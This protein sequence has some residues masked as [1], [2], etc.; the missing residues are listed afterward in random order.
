MKMDE[1]AHVR[2]GARALAPRLSAQS[3][4]QLAVRMPR[5]VGFVVHRELVAHRA[6]ADAPA[7]AAL[8]A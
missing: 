4:W 2:I 7:W 3:A 1:L 8:L 5:P 6:D